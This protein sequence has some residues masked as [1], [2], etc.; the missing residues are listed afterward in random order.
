MVDVLWLESCPGVGLFSTDSLKD[1]Q[2]LTS[3]VSR[4]GPSV[5]WTYLEVGCW[6]LTLTSCLQGLRPGC[7]QDRTS[8]VSSSFPA[9]CCQ[10]FQKCVKQTCFFLLFFFKHD[11]WVRSPPLSY[12]DVLP[13]KCFI[14]GC[15][16]HHLGRPR[17]QF[18]HQALG[19]RPLYVQNCK[20][21]L[22]VCEIITQ[23]KYFNAW[24]KGATWDKLQQWL[25]M[26]PSEEQRF[27][28]HA[29]PELQKSCDCR[30]KRTKS[31]Q[32]L[33]NCNKMHLCCECF[34]K[35]FSA[36]TDYST[37]KLLWRIRG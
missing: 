32:K 33:I 3:A 14:L 26:S 2:L 5:A 16:A 28:H 35:L 1:G 20:S 36:E 9:P 6:T 8:T 13:E 25:Q 30:S 10:R 18:S 31:F 12:S 29:N 15:E 17:V 11:R 21:P 24:L 22:V 34:E 19:Q 4:V 7:I 23:E 37:G 27:H